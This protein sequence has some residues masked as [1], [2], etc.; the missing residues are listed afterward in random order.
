MCSCPGPLSHVEHHVPRPRPPRI[1]SLPCPPA[2]VPVCLHVP[3]SLSSARPHPPPDPTHVRFP[4]APPPLPPCLVILKCLGR[5]LFSLHTHAGFH[6]PPRWG[7]QACASMH[8][9]REQACQ[10]PNRVPALRWAHP[11]WQ[12]RSGLK[13]WWLRSCWCWQGAMGGEEEGPW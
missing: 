11:T 2:L 1:P 8:R 5:M 3:S 6:T 7:S 4:H 9:V 13:V 12:R 10:P